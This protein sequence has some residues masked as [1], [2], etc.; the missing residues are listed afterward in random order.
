[1][2]GANY[3]GEAYLADGPSIEISEIPI[4]SARLIWDQVGDRKYENGLDRGVLYLSDGRAIPW[5]GLTSIVEAENR[6]TSSNYF[7]GMKISTLVTTG[8]F[9]ATLKAFT[10]PEEFEEIQGINNLVDGVYIDSQPVRSFDL[11]YRTLVGTDLNTDAGYKIHILYNVIALP[12]DKTY[13]TLTNSPSL[14]EFEW[15]I[16]AVQEELN[17]HSPTSHIIIDTTQ[18]GLPFVQ[19]IEALLYGTTTSRP[20]LPAFDEFVTFLKS[21]SQ[22][23]GTVLISIVDNGDGTWTATTGQ[24]DL[25]LV[26]SDQSFII[27]DANAEYTD[28][29]YE[30]SNTIVD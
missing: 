4:V 15:G 12:K 13:A 27:V 24:D 23:L 29:Q 9:S 25:I 5:N 2:I 3:L 16:S 8:D 1:M 28:D 30:L 18:V 10:Y 17:G 7:D 21:L 6:E 20:S 26:N 11:S 22:T 14:L 19:A